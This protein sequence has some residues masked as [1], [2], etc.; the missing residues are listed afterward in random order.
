MGMDRFVVIAVLRSLVRF[1]EVGAAFCALTI[2]WSI[3]QTERTKHVAELL[4]RGKNSASN[5]TNSWD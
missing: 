5:R 2:L 1:G 3:L 4:F